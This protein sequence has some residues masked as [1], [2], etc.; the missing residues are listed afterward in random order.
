MKTNIA[1]SACVMC[2]ISLVAALGTR[3]PVDHG[4]PAPRWIASQPTT[5]PTTSASMVAVTDRVVHEHR[6]REPHA[7]ERQQRVLPGQAHEVLGALGEAEGGPGECERQERHGDEGG[8]KDVEVQRGRGQRHQE[9]G[10]QRDGGS[11]QQREPQQL[12]GPAALV[13][14]GHPTRGHGL[15]AQRDDGPD[16]EQAEEGSQLGEGLRPEQPCPQH[17][18]RIAED[19][20]DGHAGRD[21]HARAEQPA[22]DAG[23]GLG[24]GDGQAHGCWILALGGSPS[25][26]A[27]DPSR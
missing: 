11:G 12:V 22:T 17:R 3:A 9:Q 14:G 27:L 16:D 15:H 2:A 24:R 21:E 4:S 5:P 25:A 10:D 13:A 18:E 19:L 7:R 1:S 8:R 23:T 26:P 6:D 20:A